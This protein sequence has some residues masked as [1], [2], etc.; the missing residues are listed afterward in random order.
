MRLNKILLK[1]AVAAFAAACTLGT[2]CV[3]GSVAWAAGESSSTENKVNTANIDES[4][5][6]NTSITLH[7][8]EGPESKTQSDGTAIT[9][10][11]GESSPLHG[12]KPVR[13]V[14]FTIWRVKKKAATGST[15]EAIDLSTSAGWE[16]IKD[17]ENLSNG[18]AKAATSNAAGSSNSSTTATYTAEQ[19][20]TG[21]A[22]KY[23]KD[24]DN[25][26]TCTSG[27][28]GSCKVGKKEGTGDTVTTTLPMGLYYIEETDTNNAEIKE[29]DGTSATWKKVSITKHVV[30]F[31]VTTPLPNPNAKDAAGAW[32][33]DVNVY[34]KNDISKNRPN[35][36][37]EELNRKD[38]EVGDNGTT[39]TW[40]I[41]VPLS[42]PQNGNDEYTQIG[43]VDKLTNG[44]AYKEIKSARI[45]TLGEDGQPAKSSTGTVV[46]DVKLKEGDTEYYT[47]DTNTTDVVKFTLTSS[48]DTSTTTGLSKALSAYNATVT[49]NNVSTNAKQTATLVVE[50]VTKFK[51]GIK[52]RDFKN[53][54][55]TFV[56]DNKTGN[57]EDTKNPC[58]PG[59]QRPECN[60]DNTPT[61]DAHFGTLTVNKY[62]TQKATKQSGNKT[63]NITLP[64]NGAKFD[65]YEV[66]GKVSGTS[67]AAVSSTDVT[68][69]T[70]FDGSVT[71]ADGNSRIKTKADS[72]VTFNVKKVTYRKANEQTDTPVTLET[73]EKTEGTKKVEGTASVS[74]FV[75]DKS[76]SDT[77]LYCVVETEAPKGYLLD[78]R[79][80]C[81]WLSANTVGTDNA[82]ITVPAGNTLPVEN[83]K[84]TGLDKILGAL[85]MTGARG[86]VI[87]TLCGIV[88]IAGTFF[89]IVLK[90]RKEQ[91]QE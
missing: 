48:T 16:K 40:K 71:T 1:R 31:F 82:T 89:Y 72:P 7:K 54:A 32:I 47:V 66:T 13:G 62:V 59:D 10:T 5:K 91:E 55:N 86:L 28:D 74:L 8:Y 75:K 80:H 84:A 29:G 23:V 34:P 78:S 68:K 85:P 4:K 30:P 43:F 42:A 17:I 22:Q 35:K 3:A 25:V 15:D 51:D 53:M 50:L 9:D 61:D 52:A 76:S 79:P 24:T 38:F 64:L 90:R 36:E 37:V 88:G 60:E 27:D 63:E 44:L 57:G 65:L 6:A 70:E 39:I 2:C 26:Y 81:I 87:L 33:Y 77:K 19:L 41:S 21:T 73:K 67:T 69:T 83:K 20:M 11:T 18:Q 45:V 58:V 14:K 12:K 56:D 49:N 46:A